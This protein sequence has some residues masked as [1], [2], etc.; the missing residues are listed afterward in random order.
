MTVWIFI[1]AL[2]QFRLFE[3]VDRDYRFSQTAA[4]TK[5]T[6]G[7]AVSNGKGAELSLLLE[8]NSSVFLDGLTAP[9]RPLLVRFDWYSR[10]NTP[11]HI[12]Y[13][14]CSF[15]FIHFSHDINCVV[16]LGMGGERPKLFW[17][18]TDL[19]KHIQMTG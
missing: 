17:S 16:Y 5:Q 3:V 7:V 13:V 1:L 12:G 2:E 14:T 19:W 11:V 4:A 6:Q 18:L 15:A 9:W 8:L 10:K